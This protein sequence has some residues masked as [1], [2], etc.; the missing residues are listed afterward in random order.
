VKYRYTDGFPYTELEK[1][2]K[3]ENVEE[4]WI[5]FAYFSS[6]K[7]L[8]ILE[9]IKDRKTTAI[10]NIIFSSASV[11]PLQEIVDKIIYMATFPN[12]NFHLVETPLMHAKLFA[13]KSEK[14]ISLYLGSGNLTNRAISSNIETGILLDFDNSKTSINYIN[15]LSQKCKTTNSIENII[16]KS[17]FSHFHSE[18]LF[19]ALEES[20]IRQSISISP[21]SVKKIIS[22]SREDE[23]QS[24]ERT[25]SIKNKRS[26]NIFILNDNERNLLLRKEKILKDEIKKYFAVKLDSYGWV[27]SLWSLKHIMDKEHPVNQVYSDFLKTLE[28]MRERYKKIEYRQI[29][30]DQ[31]KVYIYEWAEEGNVLF[32]E[33]QKDS[34]KNFL[35]KFSLDI[36]NR[37]SP[38]KK[39]ERLY[40]RMNEN[41]NIISLLNPYKI[42]DDEMHEK[43]EEFD[44]LSSDR[45]NLLVMCELAIKLRSKK[46][47]KIPSV[48]WFDVGLD[49][50]IHNSYGYESI[51]MYK[52]HT[53]IQLES[54]ISEIQEISDLDDCMDRYCEITGFNLALKY[55]ITSE[56]LVWLDDGD[57][58]TGEPYA[59]IN[60]SKVRYNLSLPT[61]AP[62]KE[63]MLAFNAEKIPIEW[64]LEENYLTK[65]IGKF[66]LGNNLK[67]YF[68][69]KSSSITYLYTDGL[70]PENIS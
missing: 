11:N 33:N 37:Q 16:R 31:I 49:K 2:I 3:D 69:E 13:A 47:P 63:V 52:E 14:G 30:S 22:S 40:N 42:G 55:P 34:I 62:S 58:L 66:V 1:F 9:L 18:I 35:D 56:L 64:D 12:F 17:M 50:N 27:S 29:L 57:T 61:N 28:D 48:W 68:D 70:R 32:S 5:A 15:K 21:N 51:S 46:P 23:Q 19:L 45:V 67:F 36:D 7:V 25:V 20:K 65:K 38:Y 26:L 44:I 39:I 59:F 10:V 41:S 6:N 53:R 54:I 43:N 8:E 24:E 4:L 60:S